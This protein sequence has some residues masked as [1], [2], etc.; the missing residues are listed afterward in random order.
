M[1]K[2]SNRVIFFFTPFHEKGHRVV[3]TALDV[4]EGDPANRLI[5][6]Y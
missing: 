6:Y 4:Y 2:W 3:F 5:L 1:E